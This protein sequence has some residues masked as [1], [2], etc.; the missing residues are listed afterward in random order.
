MNNF[1]LEAP[2]IEV[3]VKLE[4][5]EFFRWNKATASTAVLWDTF[6]A[7]MRGILIA[8]KAFREKQRG[9]VRADWVSKI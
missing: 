6:Q 5:R 2:G 8:V 3:K 1:L 4:I 7:D 9:L